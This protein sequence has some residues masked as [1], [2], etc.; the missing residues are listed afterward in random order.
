MFKKT[1]QLEAIKHTVGGKMALNEQFNP[2][3]PQGLPKRRAT[4][5]CHGVYKTK[6]H[7]NPPSPRLSKIAFSRLT[8]L[9]PEN[10]GIFLDD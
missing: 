4:I 6:I 8:K 10:V 9:A 5:G 3:E 2:Q 1:V 7:K